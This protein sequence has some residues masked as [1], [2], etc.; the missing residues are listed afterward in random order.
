MRA[1]NRSAGGKA[2]AKIIA[3]V[4]ALYD[5]NAR[6]ARELTFKAGDVINVTHKSTSGQWQG[7][8]RGKT[9]T[10]PASLVQEV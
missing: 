6:N 2:S 8:F 3:Q 7:E 5:Y 4:K 9:G 1:I 10:F